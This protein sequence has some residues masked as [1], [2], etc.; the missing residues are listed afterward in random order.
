MRALKYYIACTVDRFISREDGS[1]DFF[2]ADGPHLDDQVASFP[3]TIPE[4]LRDALGA[5]R[6]GKWFDTVLMGRKTY[7]VGLKFGVTNPYPH[8]EQYVFSRNMSGSPDANV[9]LVSDDAVGFVQGL[10]QQA[11]KDI[12]LC[13]G[14]ELAFRLFSEIDELVLKVSPILL[15]AGIPLFAGAVPQTSLDLI[16]SKI[17]SN[18][19]MWLR[20]RRKR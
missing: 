17:Y 2:P 11:G 8:L 9:R 5:H 19:C 20:H 7:E 4:H 1:L 18:G 3:E 13:G 14:G 10:K 15:G 12:W 6:D 16:D